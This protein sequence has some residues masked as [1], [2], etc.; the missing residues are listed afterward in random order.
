LGQLGKLQ[1]ELNAAEK[2]I[3]LDPKHADAWVNKSHA[4]VHLGNYPAALDSAEKAIELDPKLA[5]AWV[6]KAYFLN[7]FNKYSDALKRCRESY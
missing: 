4:F 3:E 6:N 7:I 5:M 2:A 1:D